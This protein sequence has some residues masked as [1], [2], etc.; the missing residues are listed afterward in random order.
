M[1]V[2]TLERNDKARIIIHSKATNLLWA[3]G[4][5]HAFVSRF[6]RIE[7]EIYSISLWFRSD[8]KGMCN[9]P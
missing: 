1:S 7:I 3:T 9:A 8:F 5:A 2:D 6:V 4:F